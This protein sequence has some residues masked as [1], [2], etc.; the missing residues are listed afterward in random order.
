MIVWNYAYIPSTH[1]KER[2]NIIMN[3]TKTELFSVQHELNVAAVDA[4]DLYR[5]V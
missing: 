5:K 4:V 2:K 1:K 3:K